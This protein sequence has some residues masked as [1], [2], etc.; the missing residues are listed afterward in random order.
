MNRRIYHTVSS[1][2]LYQ[3]GIGQLRSGLNTT[4]YFNG[5]LP[6]MQRYIRPRFSHYTGRQYSSQL[7]NRARA[8][9]RWT[10]AVLKSLNTSEELNRSI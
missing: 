4:L 6:T 1:N 5:Y 10:L 2:R 9:T 8:K 3:F 7:C